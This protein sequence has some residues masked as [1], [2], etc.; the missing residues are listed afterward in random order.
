[1]E[2][3]DLEYWSQQAGQWTQEYYSK[4]GQQPVLS[5]VKPGE[6]KA[7]LHDSPPEN[8]ESMETIF[9]DF[10]KII[11]SG[12][13]HWQHPRFFA[14]FNGN[15][16]PA[17]IVAEQ[18]ANGIGA[19]GMLWQTSPSVTELE[20]QMVHWFRQ[21]LDLPNTFLG[22]IQDTATIAT[23]NAV[24]TMRERGLNWMGL[25]KGINQFPTLKVYASSENHSSIEKAVRLSG[26]GSDNLRVPDKLPNRSMDP[27]SLRSMILADLQNG[28]IPVGVILCCGGTAAGAFDQIEDTIKV[29]KEF[30]LYV[31]V[32]AAWA[33]SAMICPEFR[34]LWK[35]IEGADSIV[36]NPHKW[37]G[38]QL[39]CSIQLLAKPEVQARTVGIQ[40]DYLKT[41]GIE[42]I[43]N[44]SE[45]TIA[46]G[47]RFRALKIW[48]TLR[49]YGLKGLRQ[50]IRDHVTWIKELEQ[51]FV[52]DPEFEVS[53]STPLA[54]FGFRFIPEG[55]DS[56]QITNTL[57]HAI[58]ADGRVYLTHT[59]VDGSEIIRVTAG[60]YLTTRNDVLMVYDIVKE[61]GNRLKLTHPEH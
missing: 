3:K 27:N 1:M 39:D 6:I 5:Q 40:P 19:N 29:A 46:L 30:D 17:S 33:G 52:N 61:F 60:T 9:E 58:N 38:I 37:L 36:I 41:D 53:V 18:L 14:Y 59:T 10:K 7:K 35:G 43:T 42:N 31:H 2:Y 28:N 49:A 11:P 23:F 16:S 21:A 34:Y 22:L 4:I 55:F 13:T 54:L 48:F 25:T 51:K 50:L 8:P 12:L 32:D 47:R 57:C 44:F 20:E 15:A 24:L 26:I 45:L 56:N